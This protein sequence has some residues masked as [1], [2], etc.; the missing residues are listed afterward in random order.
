MAVCKSENYE[1]EEI[2]AHSLR[3][4]I[5]TNWLIAFCTW[6]AEIIRKVLTINDSSKIIH[7]PYLEA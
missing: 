3:Q 5:T 1:N 6:L 7:N 4:V 2:I